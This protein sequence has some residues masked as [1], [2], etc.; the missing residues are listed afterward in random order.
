MGNEVYVDVRVSP[1]VKEFY[2]GL[3]GS[4]VIVPDKRDYIFIVMRRLMEKVPADYKPVKNNETHLK[5][6]IRQCNNS[7]RNERYYPYLQGNH[8]RLVN[9]Y[10]R[11]QFRTLFL[12]YMLAWSRRGGGQKNGIEDFCKVYNISFNNINYEMLKKLWDR[13]KEKMMMRIADYWVK[14]GDKK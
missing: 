13:S 12:N 7:N 6:L 8:Q 10:L 4:N 5:I 14:D 2:S 11:K 9:N 3:Y 1:V